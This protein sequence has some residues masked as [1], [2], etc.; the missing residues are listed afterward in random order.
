M[1]EDSA[2]KRRTAPTATAKEVTTYESLRSTI[3]QKSKDLFLDFI[4]SDDIKAMS[5][6]YMYPLGGIILVVLLAVFI[7]LFINGYYESIRNTYLSPM[8]GD[9]PSKRCVTI[10]TANTGTYLATQNGYWQGALGFDFGKASYELSVTSF[11]M[12]KSNYSHLMDKAYVAIGKLNEIMMRSDLTTNLIVW[13]SVVFLPV[14]NNIAQRFL[15]TG[16]PMAVFHRE[17]VS[18]TVSSVLGDCNETAQASFD[19]VTGI[20][21]LAYNYEQYSNNPV[22]NSSLPPALAGYV[23]ETDFNTFKIDVDVRSIVTAIA[24]NT[25][26]IAIN[27]LVEIPALHV[28]YPFEGM[29]YDVNVYYDQKYTGME[30]ISCIKVYDA[31]SGLNNTNC[32]VTITGNLYAIPLFNHYGTSYTMPIPCNCSTAT[33]E[34]LAD[35]SYSCNVF[36]L[37]AGVLFYPTASQDDLIRLWTTVGVVTANGVTSN[38]TN[39]DSFTAQFIGSYFGRTSPNRTL[40]DTPEYR[41]SA[42]NFCTVP[43]NSGPCSLVTFSLFDTHVRNWAVTNYY[44]QLT[45]GACSNSL[46]P[47]YEEW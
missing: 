12:S 33:P 37:L 18:G 40:F 42:Y 38:P 2:F 41:E 21:S 20:I 19:S 15:L 28:V 30:P 8:T 17:K 25:G 7:V 6:E 34:E 9:T 31:V 5:P 32:V 16:S 35:S 44:Y 46:Y 22:C 24:V 47:P 29:N 36:S 27:Q 11:V 23:A 4:P 45:N 43:G 10:S 14:D 39:A 13:M 26:F 3:S 1:S